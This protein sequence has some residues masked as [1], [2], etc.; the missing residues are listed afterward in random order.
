MT[1]MRCFQTVADQ[2]GETLGAGQAA[3]TKLKE[4][5]L[6]TGSTTLSNLSGNASVGGVQNA[7]AGQ[8]LEASA[9]SHGAVQ[10][11]ASN[12]EVHPQA[13]MYLNACRLVGFRVWV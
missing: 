10:Q 13:P 11:A 4:A 1:K 9:D 6:L 3:V 7:T 8:S 2:G 12:G 5:P